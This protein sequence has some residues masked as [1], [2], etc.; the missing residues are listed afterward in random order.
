MKGDQ[1]AMCGEEEITLAGGLSQ[2]VCTVCV[3]ESVCV[4]I[5]CVSEYGCVSV[6]CV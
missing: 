5:L 6:L 3:I 2:T 1:W 4:S